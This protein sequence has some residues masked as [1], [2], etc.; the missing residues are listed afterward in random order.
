MRPSESIKARCEVLTEALVRVA[1]EAHGI[2]EQDWKSL[3]DDERSEGQQLA[4]LSAWS[5]A[6]VEHIDTE[7]ERRAKF[8]QDITERLWA[9]EAAAGTGPV[10]LAF[11]QLRERAMAAGNGAALSHPRYAPSAN[12]VAYERTE[13]TEE[14]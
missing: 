10:D 7:T 2:N 5:L 1:L 4:G 8:E 14:P 13:E 9:L 6:I 3:S 12:A 11:D